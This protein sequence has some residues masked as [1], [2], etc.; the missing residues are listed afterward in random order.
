MQQSHVY[1]ERCYAAD[2][3]AL[4][5]PAQKHACWS[6]WLEHYTAGLPQDRVRYARERV[7]A[8][9]HGEVV[10]RMRGLEE[11]ESA[12]DVSGVAP[13]FASA[14]EPEDDPNPRPLPHTA[15][16]ACAARACEPHYRRC[17]GRC[18]IPSQECSAAC[19][20]ELQACARGCF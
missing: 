1:F 17:L 12:S 3:D 4:I 11:P 8:I 18:D 7:A 5:P 19:E 13:S 10:P 9:E 20:V 16:P 6:A 15:S 14:N 2:F